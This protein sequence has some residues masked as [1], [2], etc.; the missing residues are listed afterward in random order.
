M[1]DE[2]VGK[3]AITQRLERAYELTTT[4]MEDLPEKLDMFIYGSSGVGKTHL[5]GTLDELAAGGAPVL[6]LHREGGI[7]TI[8]HM[9]NFV[10]HEVT[11]TAVVEATRQAFRDNPLAYSA[12]VMDSLTGLYELLLLEVVASEVRA[13]QA[14][15]RSKDP[16][17]P[18]LR[19]YLKAKVTMERYVRTF[20]RLPCHFI[21]TALSH[22]EKD[23]L[24]GAIST[25]PLLAGKLEHELQGR[26]DIV[27]YLIVRATGKEDEAGRER[28]LSLAGTKKFQAKSRFSGALPDVMF[29]PTFKEI[30]EAIFG[31]PP[32]AEPPAP[33]QT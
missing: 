22:T 27:G 30:L 24:S 14:K 4:P 25:L 9:R 3:R 31:K 12:V 2:K 21:T 32:G 1:T 13:A 17:V 29:N 16:I 23:D 33:E 7:R 10:Y 26:F 18:E 6:Y 28:L 5:V 19:D 20:C 15:G 8:R 11:S